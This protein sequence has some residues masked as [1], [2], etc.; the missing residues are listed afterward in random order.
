MKAMNMIELDGA[1]GEG[2]GQILRTAL[3]LSMIT[4]TPF[5]MERIRARRPKPGLLRQHLTAVQ[6]AAKISGAKVDGAEPG[7]A[8]LAFEPGPIRGGDYR[9]AIGTAG[10]CTLVLQTVLPAL[11]FADG[12]SSLT[13]S[14][15]THNPAAPP[16]DF[17]IRSWQPLM[18][19]MGVDMD[20]QL[21]RHGF[22]PAGGGEITAAVRP[23]PA[24]G[25]LQ[26]A[27]K[28]EFVAGK[29]IG[30]V[31]GVPTDVA[32]RELDRVEAQL[33]KL[34]RE[35]R[36][37]PSRE[38]P[39]NVLM[40]ELVYAGI[41]AVFTGFGE[42]G[43]PA[44]QVADQVAK[45]AHL[46]RDA[47]AA[48][49]EHLADQLLAPMALAGGG[50]FSTTGLSSHF[51]TNREVVMAFLPVAILTREEEGMTWVALSRR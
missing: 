4:G 18:R 32:V 46:Y 44:E 37:L 14:G 8:T 3:T 39:G 17:L 26:L 38:G 34:D 16:A 20:I 23:V 31:A 6:A 29:A 7:S 47:P 51:Q 41:T 5:R 28:G 48:V 10:S 43:L 49:D 21:V 2:G 24:L 33:G 9:F 42:R 50:S 36:L 19:A 45:A 1:Q 30:V 15:G 40:V 27:R 25:H 12:P 11:W 13:V 22:Y 35:T